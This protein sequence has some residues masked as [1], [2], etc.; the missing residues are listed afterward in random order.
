MGTNLWF[1]SFFVHGEIKLTYLDQ[2]YFGEWRK[3]FIYWQDK[4]EYFT[5]IK[6]RRI[7]TV[8]FRKR[9]I[10]QYILL[11]LNTYILVIFFTFIF[12]IF[13]LIPLW[14]LVR[15]FCRPC[16]IEFCIKINSAIETL[17][18]PSWVQS[19]FASNIKRI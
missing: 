7:P 10:L 5:L 6:E 19:N 1:Y 18:I 3:S 14:A 13:L 15:N 11:L 4:K 2:R 16:Y 8:S 12:C 17:Y 9:T